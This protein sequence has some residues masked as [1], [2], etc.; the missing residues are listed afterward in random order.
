MVAQLHFMIRE[1]TPAD[2][3]TVLALEYRCFPDP[4]PISLLNK[5]RSMYPD[6]FLIAEYN[7]G[8][9]GYVIGAVRWGNV[10]H[11][12]AIGV[13]PPYRRRG[14]GSALI[15]ETLTRF[16]KKGASIARLE[17][18]KSNLAAQQ[19]YRSLGFIDRF[20]IQYY[21]EDGEAAL[22]MELPL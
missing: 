1:A 10:G 12:L 6:T 20:E 21:Y 17:V 22:T 3:K 16:R 14:M 11:I 8:I 15:R 4:Y 18:R 7:G 5:L 9:V 19:F 2:M 13:D